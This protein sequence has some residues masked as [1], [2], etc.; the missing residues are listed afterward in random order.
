MAKHYVYETQSSIENFESLKKSM[1]VLKHHLYI[2]NEI[3]IRL[4]RTPPPHIYKLLIALC[5]VI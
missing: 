2:L 5:S 1:Y 4:F 3:F